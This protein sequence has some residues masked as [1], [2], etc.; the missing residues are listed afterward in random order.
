MVDILALLGNGIRTIIMTNNCYGLR[1][2]VLYGK[3]KRNCEK[4]EF[5]YYYK[6]MLHPAAVFDDFED[7]VRD[8]LLCCLRLSLRYKP[9]TP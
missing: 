8:R 1:Y 5:C 2:K 3:K 4:S 7:S 6:L 9:Y